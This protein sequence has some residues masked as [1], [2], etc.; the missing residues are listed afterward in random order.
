M[1]DMRRIEGEIARAMAEKRQKEQAPEGYYIEY[2][3]GNLKSIAAQ[4]VRAREASSSSRKLDSDRMGRLQQAAQREA[5]R[6][7]Q[8]AHNRGRDM[9]REG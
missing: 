9:G 5:A 2:F 8:Q 6:E 1:P 4:D 7:G 3:T